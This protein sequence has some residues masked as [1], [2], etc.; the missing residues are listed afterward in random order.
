MTV[1]F[2]PTRPPRRG[3][4]YH[5]R[6]SEGPLFVPTTGD[7]DVS[8]PEGRFITLTLEIPRIGKP[9]HRESTYTLVSRQ[10][11]SSTV[12]FSS[13]IEVAVIGAFLLLRA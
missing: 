6:I 9:G 12:G 5:A 8:V 11:E 3:C 13:S 2:H 10:G 7:Q 4:R 1:S